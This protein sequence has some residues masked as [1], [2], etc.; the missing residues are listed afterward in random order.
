MSIW[1]KV[2][3]AGAGF[4]VG[5]PVGALVGAV[6]G[7]FLIDQES[8]PGVTFTI[9]VI[10]LAGKMAKADGVVS[11]AELEAFGRVFK[12]PPEEEANVRRIFNLA[13]QDVAGF[14]AYAGQIARLFVGNPAVLEDILDGLFEIAKA[15][16]VLHPGESA[17]LERVAEIFGLAPNEFRRIRAAHFAPELTDPYVILG[18]SYVAGEEEIKQTYRRLVREN[19]PDSLIARGVPQEFVRL[20]ND[21]L[22]AI[23]AAYEKIQ[24]ERGLK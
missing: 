22:A 19:H 11:N 16:G 1:G 24:G 23:N 17:F 3:G 14:E 20:A 21:K 15:D 5:G 13:R 8:D 4:L 12:V 18:V 10:A 9:A 2:S 6:A 7:H